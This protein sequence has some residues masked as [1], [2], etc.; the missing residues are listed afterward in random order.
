MLVVALALGACAGRLEPAA[1]AQLAPGDAKAAI[2]TVEGVTVVA[3]AN[4]W[5]AFPTDLDRLMTPILVTIRNDRA[6]PV[7]VKSGEIALRAPN[8]RRFAALPPLTIEGTLV[9]P[10][11]AFPSAVGSPYGPAIPGGGT[12][13]PW[14]RSGALGAPYGW[15]ARYDGPAYATV[16]LPTRD[17]LARA[18]PDTPIRPAEVAQGFVYLERVGPKGTSGDLV[19]P[20]VDAV[21]GQVL[22]EVRL[23][24]VFQ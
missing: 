13:D 9:E 16:R 15:D 24:F 3:R 18:L 17:M 2:A 20:L 7:S 6:E 12:F 8:G 22:G 19:L 10:V 5:R 23:P 1:T 11:S 14:Y 21:S 4:A